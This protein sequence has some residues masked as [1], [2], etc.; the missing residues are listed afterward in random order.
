MPLSS[1]WR[2]LN[3]PVQQLISLLLFALLLFVFMVS[4]S[5]VVMQRVQTCMDS[6][7]YNEGLSLRSWFADE[8]YY[9]RGEARLLA[10]SESSHDLLALHDETKLRYLMSLYQTTHHADGIYLITDTSD[11]FTTS[12][13]PS[14]DKETILG[15]ELVR[16]GFNGQIFAE[17]ITVNERIWLMSVAPHMTPEGVI[18][19]V[20]LITREVD[21]EFLKTLAG[22]LHKEIVLTDGTVK[23]QSQLGEMPDGIIDSPA[24]I[25]ENQSNDLMQ[26][27]T[28]R[29][30]GMTYRMLAM[31]LMTTHSSSY[32][33]VL[34][35]NAEIMVDTRW[36]IIRWGALF[37]LIIIILL[38]A[39]VQFHVVEIFRPL[40]EL[41]R[42]TQRIAAGELDGPLEPS[43]VAEVY[44]LATHF[45][46]MRSRL[47]EQMEQERSVSEL[48]EAEVQEKSLTL[49][50]M[51]RIRERH[52]TQ[53][54]SSQEEERRRVSRELHDET[55]QE[56]ANIIVR[57]GTLA[58]IVDDEGTL[59]Q[60]QQLRS[61]AAK[62]LEGVNRI[63][64]DL[65][66]GLL[67][68]YGL[69]PAVQ[70]YANARLEA[71][72][73]RVK[74]KVR[75]TPREFSPH[76]QASIYRMVQ[77][78]INNITQHAQ[79]SEVLIRFDWLDEQLRIEIQD[80]GRG[81][82]A[83]NAGTDISGHYGLLGIRER[84]SLL[85]GSLEIH[86]SP[87]NGAHLIIQIPYALNIVRENGQD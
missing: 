22:R 86:S 75:E 87:G 42:S 81:F 64:M 67:D 84:A 30:N 68:E 39:L 60:I 46:E 77:E 29:F 2:R 48:L 7:L 80:D 61:E 78:A 56:L 85:N 37:S 1:L 59:E 73:I 35:E 66:P 52:L 45:E 69:V 55:S 6:D 41:V 62:A 24:Q 51:C 50:D 13:T 34:V 40:R 25:L 23:V 83:Q 74:M 72:G 4:L 33:F 63:V 27:Y 79:A 26:P 28:V 31:P 57:L 70:W 16:M 32:A 21:A 71:Q 15:L 5:V 49:D 53:L 10:E 11:I 65:R 12:S 3:T 43:G 47:V 9:M 17:M 38:L 14:L 76:A 44:E 36:T 54:I 58:R 8:V 82:E 18:D 19:A 20:F